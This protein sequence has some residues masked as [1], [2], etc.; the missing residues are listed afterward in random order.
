[1]TRESLVQKPHIS[2]ICLQEGD[3]RKYLLDTTWPPQQTVLS[4]L[5]IAQCSLNTD[6]YRMTISRW[7][8][9][10]HMA[11]FRF[12]IH[13]VQKQGACIFYI[14]N[15]NEIAFSVQ[16]KRELQQSQTLF[17]TVSIKVLKE[18]RKRRKERKKS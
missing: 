16:K 6:N 18:K 4:T 8:L 7:T 13:T 15:I 1:M 2:R 11:I 3:L 12:R 10:V 9:R 17:K 14:Q 5:N